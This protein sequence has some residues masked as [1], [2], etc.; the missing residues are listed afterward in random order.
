[1]EFNNICMLSK[2]KHRHQLACHP[3]TERLF[4][5]FHPSG[6]SHFELSIPRL[7]FSLFLRYLLVTHLS[8]RNAKMPIK[9]LI[10]QNNI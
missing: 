5:I 2:V 3:E 1:M 7:H 4:S 9:D 6:N 8:I 10:L